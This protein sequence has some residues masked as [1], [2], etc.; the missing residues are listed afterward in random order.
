M[1][2]VDP[3]MLEPVRLR[4]N[5]FG[6]FKAGSPTAEKRIFLMARSFWLV[7]SVLV[8]VLSSCASGPKATGGL[9]N[10]KGEGGL[11]NT[12]GKSATEVAAEAVTGTSDKSLAG[13]VH[14]VNLK[15][16]N[17]DIPIVYNDEVE[18]WV[19]YFTGAGRKHFQVYLER[20]AGIE[21]VI[22]PK[23]KKSG[24][25]QDLIYLAMIESGFSPAAYS[26]AGASGP[27][28]FMRATGR[29]YGLQ[30]NWWVD[31][32]RDPL[33]STDAAIAYLDRLHDEFGDWWLAC[34]AYNSGEAKIRRAIAK[35]NTREF[36][37]IAENR[38]ALRRE[39]KDYVPKMMAAAIIGKNAEQFG[40]E[41]HPT[42]TSLIDF[43]EVSIPKSENLRTIAR[44]ANVDR[45]TIA[46]LNPELLRCCTPPQRTPYKIRVPKGESAKLLTAAIDA[47]E[48]GTYQDFRRYVIRKG[49]SISRIASSTGVPSEA[50]LSMNEIRNIKSLKP[51]TELV[52]PDRGHAVG[53]SRRMVASYDRSA[54]GKVHRS[55][56][57]RRNS[58]ISTVASAPAP[59]GA[60]AI[61]HVIKKGD[62]LT[63][64]S[65][66]YS[67]RVEQIRRWNNVNGSKKLRPG[68]RIK[69]YVSNDTKFSATP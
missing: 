1:P 46:E 17:F 60:H 45:T 30:S 33:K 58:S 14:G 62:T 43:E 44:V 27:W 34:A 41:V 18:K 55:R 9:L 19:D 26:H 22:Q 8:L 39:T 21:P 42:D 64:I 2:Q 23:L 57:S 36:F 68:R 15:N 50:I 61:V 53:V 52:I 11:A 56:K 3:Q 54:T 4:R 5:L 6:N 13:D 35:L 25:P 67:V 48:I 65:H 49:D 31:E 38:K 40:F 29:L 63:A 66:R 28:Q 32:R 37:E 59:Q 12:D 7:G 16:R 10:T 47:G 69:L 24:L 51:G 20:K